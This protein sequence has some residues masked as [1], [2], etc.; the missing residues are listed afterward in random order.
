MNSSQHINDIAKRLGPALKKKYAA[1]VRA[2]GGGLWKKNVGPEIE[3]ELLDLIVYCYTREE[4]VGRLVAAAKKVLAR[5]TWI[6]DGKE[7]C[8]E[9]ELRAALAPL[10][11]QP[12]KGND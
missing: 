8:D 11:N 4:Q 7:F 12:T 5:S 9:P 2:H 6:V 1:G 3:N 10:L